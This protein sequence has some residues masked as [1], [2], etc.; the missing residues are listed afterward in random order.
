MGQCDAGSTAGAAID[1]ES[2]LWWLGV[3]LSVVSSIL[4]NLGV[5]TQKLSL[6]RE[7]SLGGKPR[8]YFCQPLWFTGLLLV[9]VGS[10]GDFAALGFAAQS[11]VTPVGAVTMVANLFFASMWLG[12][13]LS[14]QDIFGTILILIG[15][16]LAA[17]FADKSEQCFTL[18]ELVDLYKEP[19]FLAYASSVVVIMISFYVLSR[20]CEAVKANHGHTSGKYL[21]LQRVHP[22]C[23]GTHWGPVL[24]SL[25]SQHDLKPLH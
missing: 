19:A 2:D 12:E 10:L 9:F 17:A 25:Y 16:V 15:A 13:Q 4:S 5:N 6:M 20:H 11:L 21:R 7:A 14:T 3:L 18:T 23:Y 24:L 1:E 8:S 22:F